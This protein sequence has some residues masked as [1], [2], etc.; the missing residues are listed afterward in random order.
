[1]KEAEAGHERAEEPKSSKEALAF[2]S[3]IGH[4]EVNQCLFADSLVT[5]SDS[6]KELGE[7]CVSIQRASYDDEPCYMVHANSHGAIDNIPCGTSIMAYVSRSLETLEENLHEYMKMQE[8]MLDRKVNIVKRDDCLVVTRT[9]TEKEEVKK[10]TFT[11]PLHSLQG[12]VSEASNLLILRILAQQRKVP[13]KMMFLSFNA[14][15][16]ITVST[17]RELG[18]KKQLV[19]K[20]MVDVFGIERT[21]SFG[22]DIQATWQCYF[23]QDGHLSSRVQM[24]SPVTM[25]LLQLPP[26]LNKEERDQKTVFDKKPL[27]WEEDME[28]HSKFLDRKE[29]LKADHSSYV[30]HHPELKTLLA[31]FL[32]FLL[33]RKPE[34]VFSFAHNFFAPFDSQRPP[35]S[36]FKTS[37]TMKV[38]EGT[39]PGNKC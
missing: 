26:I 35:D 6:G 8:H 13:E 12:F 9:I 14:D 38:P 22:D 7:F 15:T 20:D 3:S 16:Q 23:L 11:L 28:L 5:V 19:G 27:I 34:D 37:Q 33:L 4:R 39:L 29:E 25:S 2:L 31:D 32:Q 18:T 36:S 24:G 21:I 1:M 17:Y 10:Q 30:R